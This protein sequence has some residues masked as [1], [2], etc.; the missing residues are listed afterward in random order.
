M[1]MSKMLLIF[2]PKNHQNKDVGAILYYVTT[3]I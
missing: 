3:L 2:L 1:T